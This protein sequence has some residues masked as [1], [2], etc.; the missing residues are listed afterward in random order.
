MTA[1][2]QARTGTSSDVHAE[3]G[4]GEVVLRVEGLRVTFSRNGRIVEAVKGVDFDVRRG[5]TLA[6][7][8]ESGS[9]KSVSVRSLMGL[10]PP[11]AHV[12]G[13]ARLGSTELLGLAGAGDAPDPRARHRDGVPEPGDVAEP[14]DEHRQAARSRRS[15]CTAAWTRPRRASAPWSC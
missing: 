3:T 1:D 7:I 6:I 5:R 10:L 12:S 11:S 15:G 9:G 4:D 14:D 13:S 8:G 2:T